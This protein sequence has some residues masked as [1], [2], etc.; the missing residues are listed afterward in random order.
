MLDVSTYDFQDGHNN[1]LIISGKMTSFGNNS[2]EASRY[3]GGSVDEDARK[4]KT[5]WRGQVSRLPLGIELLLIFTHPLKVV[6][7]FA[8]K[9][10]KWY[11]DG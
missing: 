10:N 4:R 5:A 9:E 6:K 7:V 1:S 8:M 11:R 2:F 3:E